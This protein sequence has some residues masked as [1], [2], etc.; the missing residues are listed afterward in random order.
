MAKGLA[1]AKERLREE[2]LEATDREAYR[3][4]LKDRQYEISIL[5]STRAE[6]ELEGLRK[7]IEQGMEQGQRL[8]QIRI[9][10]S[11]KRSGSPVEFIAEV[12]GLTIAEVEAL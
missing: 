9:A 5:A 7:G 11:L 1:E 4:F 6:A 8:Q 12:T 10:Q 2:N 3:Q